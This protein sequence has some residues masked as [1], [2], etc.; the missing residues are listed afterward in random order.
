MSS[1]TDRLN[2]MS[3]FDPTC[4]SR[5]VLEH[6]TGRWG[7]VTL[8]ALSDGPMRFAAIRRAV[9]GISD[10][11]LAQTLQRLEGDGLLVRRAH[12]RTSSRVEYELTGIGAPIA[13]QICALIDAIYEQVP[14]IVEH[15]RRSRQAPGT[16][17]GHR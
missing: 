4:I 3:V 16:R 6:A 2:D 8:A 11:M 1:A 17:D 13:Q 5:E 12:D 9:E 10:R 14:A 7:A 15:T